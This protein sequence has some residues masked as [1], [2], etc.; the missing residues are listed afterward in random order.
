ML[1]ICFDRYGIL[2]TANEQRSASSTIAA[3]TKSG[4]GKFSTGN[5]TPHGTRA[6]PAHYKAG[7]ARACMDTGCASRIHIAADRLFVV[8][9]PS[10]SVGYRSASHRLVKKEFCL[11]LAP[12]S[13]VRS[14]KVG[15]SSTAH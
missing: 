14:G 4:F 15:P 2:I 7:A 13:R 1:L 9:T 3:S 8:A 11:D 6:T 5:S 12:R 10:L